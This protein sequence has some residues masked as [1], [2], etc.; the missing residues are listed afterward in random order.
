LSAFTGAISDVL[1]AYPT[2]AHVLAVDADVQS[3]AQYRSEDLPIH[4]DCKGGGGTDFRPA[5]RW[6]AEN[7]IEPAALIYLT[8]LCGMFPDSD[9]GYPVLWVSTDPTGAAP[10]GD[11]VP[12][13]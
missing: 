5:F 9:P 8:D 7:G 4:V 2:T 3:V 6:V 1:A 13:G 11:V 10:F 12:I